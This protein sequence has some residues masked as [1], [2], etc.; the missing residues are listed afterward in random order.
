MLQ[1]HGITA[2]RSN[3]RD[4]IVVI[5]CCCRTFGDES[6][7]LFNFTKDIKLLPVNKNSPMIY[8]WQNSQSFSF[9]SKDL[10]LYVNGLLQ[11]NGLMLFLQ[12]TFQ[13]CK[14][15]VDWHYA[16]GKNLKNEDARTF[17]AGR[18]DRA[19]HRS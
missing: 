1:C 12:D 6:C 7:F 14:S 9:G 3:K 4:L 13:D 10:V 11:V 2:Q 8:Q 5:P 16:T 17:F 19:V 18:L 15:E